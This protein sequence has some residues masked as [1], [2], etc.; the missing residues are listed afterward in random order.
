LI[1]FKLKQVSAKGLSEDKT[2]GPSEIKNR[3]FMASNYLY[4][5]QG[6]KALKAPGE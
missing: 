2:L 3:C 6:K 4:K 5:L 1:L